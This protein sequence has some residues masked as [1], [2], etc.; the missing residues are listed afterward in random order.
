[1]AAIL[2]PTQAE[3]DEAAA[4]FERDWGAVDEVLYGVC[5][6]Y[7][8]HTDRRGLTA[9][10]VLIDRAYAAGLE[11]RV[12][13]PAGKQAITV[14]ADFVYEHRAEIDA[15]IA[16]AGPIDEPLNEAAMREI[17]DVN[18]RLCALLLGVATDG[19]TPRSFASK[20]L[21]FHN[22]ACRSSTATQWRH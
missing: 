19:K 7:P 20:Y 1:V 22:P 17:V 16:E 5:R 2:V 13:P 8:D 3:L 21:H 11:R 15:I 18:G 14:I 4:A 12:A 9:K 10:L 6:R